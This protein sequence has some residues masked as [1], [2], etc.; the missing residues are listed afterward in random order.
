MQIY[1]TMGVQDVGIMEEK[2]T[3]MG[4]DLADVRL[5]EEMLK[6]KLQET[7]EENARLQ[8]QLQ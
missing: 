4:R 5:G 2:F 7:S 8:I 6:E 3:E 1:K